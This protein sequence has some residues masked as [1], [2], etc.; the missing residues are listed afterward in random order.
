MDKQKLFEFYRTNIERNWSNLLTLPDASKLKAQF[1]SFYKTRMEILT[2]MSN[3]FRQNST[4]FHLVM[5]YL[6]NL[7][8]ENKFIIL[9][10]I[11]F[12][13]LVRRYY[14]DKK[15]SIFCKKTERNLKIL[16]FL[17]KIIAGYKPTFFLP[18]PFPKIL[19]VG[20]KTSLED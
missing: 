4:K 15:I 5:T 13:Y 9:G 14:Q 11:F 2:L 1:E 17:D 10:G 7:I 8:L 19:Y 12:A 18:G 6:K 3:D 16:K 20:F